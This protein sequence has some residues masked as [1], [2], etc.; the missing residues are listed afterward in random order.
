V[1]DNA[2]S[3]YFEALKRAPEV[4]DVAAVD[5]IVETQNQ[6][7]VPLTL[8]RLAAAARERSIQEEGEV[9]EFWC[10]FDVEWP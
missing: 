5:L 4:R 3:R 1:K 7:S 9:D 8:V 2:P 10:I 6:G